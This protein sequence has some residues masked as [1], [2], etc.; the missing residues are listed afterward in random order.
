MLAVISK[1]KEFISFL[2]KNGPTI[3]SIIAGIAAG[4]LAWNVVTI[5]QGLISAFKVWKTTTGIDD[6]TKII[7]HRNGGQSNW[8]CN[9][10]SFLQLVAAL[11]TLFC[12]DLRISETR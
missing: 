5:I 9:N 7:K 12:N 4:M 11:V 1:V 6:C 2:A 10:G 8:D 3:I